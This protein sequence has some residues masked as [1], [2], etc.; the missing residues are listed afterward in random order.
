MNVV[1]MFEAVRRRPA[2]YAW[3]NIC[4]AHEAERTTGT[5][6]EYDQLG[7]LTIT[8]LDRC[9]FLGR[10]SSSQFS[11]LVEHGVSGPPRAN[12]AAR[13]AW[14]GTIAILE[15]E[16]NRIVYPPPAPLDRPRTFFYGINGTPFVDAANAWW[17][18]LDCLDARE[19]NRRENSGLRIG[20][21][22]EPDDVVN[23][24][25]RLELPPTHARTV[26][27][28][29]KRRVEPKEGSEARRFWDEVMVRLTEVL[30][31]KG[32]V[33]RQPLREIETVPIPLRS[34]KSAPHIAGGLALAAR[35]R[36]LETIKSVV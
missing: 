25:R 21:P 26:I 24:L 30:R 5:P 19:E 11:I 13:Q 20:R 8:A 12:S 23:A 17:W 18:T 29:G 35:E 1:K 33:Q 7:H 3:I 15:S 14:D 32:I 27:A 36:N 31:A 16:M 22:C 34:L 28:W 6:V 4:A 10:I 2:E 9:V